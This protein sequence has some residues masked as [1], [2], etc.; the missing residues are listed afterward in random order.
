MEPYKEIKQNGMTGAQGE[1]CA[2]RNRKYQ[3][4]EAQAIQGHNENLIPGQ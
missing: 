1:R 3:A 4:E 2:G